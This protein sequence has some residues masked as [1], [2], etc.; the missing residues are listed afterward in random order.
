MEW[1]IEHQ[2][3]KGILYLK[4]GGV[5]DMESANIMVADLVQAAALHGCTR[6]LVDHRATTF[7]F[8]LLDYYQRPAINEK[9]GVSV[10]WKTAMVF[11]ECTPETHFMETVFQNRGY[12]FREFS[13][14]DK[15]IEWLVGK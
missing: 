1:T 15:A 9:I 5:M 4:S 13:D 11:A 6:H 12:N 8:S 14:F 10:K 3:D 7:A 2:P